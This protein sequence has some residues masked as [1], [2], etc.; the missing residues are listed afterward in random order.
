MPVARTEEHDARDA[1]G[2]EE[3]EDR[4]SVALEGREEERDGEFQPTA[5]DVVG[6]NMARMVE[7]GV[8]ADGAAG[9]SAGAA[10]VGAMG[11]WRRAG[12]EPPLPERKGFA[13]VKK[14]LPGGGEGLEMDV[15]RLRSMRTEVNQVGATCGERNFWKIVIERLFPKDSS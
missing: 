3:L 13:K 10:V 1:G 6:D 11:G 15:D 4:V 5:G 2:T 12:G 14:L 9:A 7:E 8:G